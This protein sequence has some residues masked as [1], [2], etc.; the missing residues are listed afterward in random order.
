MIDTNYILEKHTI[1]NDFT[2]N[3]DRQEYI[4]NS[5]A[6]QREKRISKRELKEKK[7]ELQRAI[8]KTY[9]E[10]VELY[11]QHD[12]E[13][14]DA[15]Q[16]ESYLKRSYGSRAGGVACRRKRLQKELSLLNE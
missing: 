8:D 4:L 14:E 12:I 5:F 10:V 2:L 13:L 1:L 16:L 9:D 6:K 7:A 15:P 11:K 3:K